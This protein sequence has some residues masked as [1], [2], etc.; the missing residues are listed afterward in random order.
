[1]NDGELID[2][3]SLVGPGV[4]YQLI[5]VV[6]PFVIRNN[7]PVRR[8]ALCDTI[9]LGDDQ[10]TRIICRLIFN[11]RS[12]DWSLRYQERNCLPLHV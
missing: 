1:M 6:F 5:L 10:N 12:D 7:Y 11:S 9:M 3:C 4:L 8:D 2:A